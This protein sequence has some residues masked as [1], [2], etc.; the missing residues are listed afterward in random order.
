MALN[1]A[2]YKVRFF[3][4]IVYA[5]SSGSHE[6]RKTSH[7]QHY[8][9]SRDNFSFFYSLFFS[10]S[11]T[12]H[13]CSPVSLTLCSIFGFSSAKTRLLRNSIISSSFWQYSKSIISKNFQLW[14]FFPL[15][16]C[17]QSENQ[18]KADLQCIRMLRYGAW[19]L[20]M[21]PST[22][23]FYSYVYIHNSRCLL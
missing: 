23:F 13:H 4:F 16:F 11:S 6:G 1:I 20:L 9:Y 5:F 21:E 7:G 22:L 15:P 14:H 3:C 2:Y 10:F 8:S 12:S 17:W 19:I 18:E